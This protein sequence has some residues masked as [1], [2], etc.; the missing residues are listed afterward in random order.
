MRLRSVQASSLSGR[1]AFALQQRSIF[2]LF[3]TTLFFVAVTPRGEAQAT[4]SV[5][6]IV[7]DPQGRVVAGASVQ[8]T[9]SVTGQRRL[10]TSSSAGKFQFPLVAPGSYVVQVNASG[11]KSFIEKNVQVLVNGTSREDAHLA[12]GEAS[13]EVTI[14][15]AAPLVE[16]SNATTGVVVGQQDVVDLPLNGRN[17]AQLGTLIPGVVAAPSGLGG[18]S[19]NA[20]PGGF[21]DA[22]GS[23]NVNG[24]RNQSNNFLLDGAQNND[25]FN[26]GFVMRPPPDAIQEFKIMTHS[27]EAQYGRNSGSVVNV[28]TRSG[29]NRYHATLWDFNREGSLAAKNFF[30]PPGAAKPQYLQNQFGAAGGGRI[31][32]DRWFFFGYYEGYR[33]K[34]ATANTL[35]VPVL[36]AAERSGNFAEL[37]TGTA[38]SS[39]C[40]A[41]GVTGGGRIIDPATGAQFCDNGQPNVIDPA[42]ESA[43]TNNLLKSYIPVPNSAQNQFVEAPPNIDNRDTVGIRSDYKWR[44]HAF[45]GRYL[46]AHQNLYAPLTPSD[47]PVTGSRQ[48]MSLFDGMISDTWILSASSI[49]VARYARQ[50]ING[51]PNK[52]SGIEPSLAGY[53]YQPSNAQALGLPNVT[54]TGYFTQGD[55]Q[56]PFASRKNYV[57]SVDDDFTWVKGRHQLQFGG[58]FRRDAIDLLYINRPNGAFT[59]NGY[60]TSNTLADFF[61]GYPYMFQQGSGNPALDGSSFTYSVYAQDAFHVNRHLTLDVGLRY[62]IN[63]PYAEAHNHLAALHPGQ[64]STVEPSAP[65][66]LVYPGDADTPRATYYAD[67]NNFAPRLGLVYDP[68]GNASTTLRVAW[69]IFYDTVPGQGD[70]FQNGTL[71]PPFQP[72]QEIDFYTRPSSAASSTYFSNP[73]NG[74]SA[75]PVGFPPGLTFIGWSLPHSFQTAQVYQYNAGIQHRV[76]STSGFEIAYVGSRG[77]HLPIF[78]EANPTMV[79]PASS[80]GSAY[81]AGARAVFPALGLTRPTFS[82]A[83]SWYDSLQASYQLRP[84]HHAHATAAYTWSHSIDDVSGL[85]IGSDSRPILPVTIGDQASIDAAMAR[86]RGNSLFDARNRLVLSFGYE[87]PKLMGSNLAKRLFVGGWQ[88]NG[89]FQAQSGSPFTAV[90]ST[91]T[92]QSLTF[93]PNQTCNPNSG[94]HHVGSASPFF[95][96]SCFALPTT[97][98]GR[99]DNSQSGNEARNVILGPRWNN[100]DASLF[101]IFS[102]SETQSVEFRFEVFDLF[103]EAHFAQPSST[104]GSS[105]FGTITSTVGSDQ[106]ILQMALKY[107]F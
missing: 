1:S 66:G 33:V 45:L 98:G 15:S 78:I 9:S 30:T 61:L 50:W 17:F 8:L 81:T 91:T 90:N 79:L 102:L 7:T 34:D 67:I 41:A 58:E 85:N 84:W 51:I 100:T 49:N 82:A 95:N 10:A 47:F 103:N 75:G 105:T 60:F 86:E 55:L 4:G 54:L 96:V 68:T 87:L 28:V 83:G 25:S 3:M 63:L 62:E 56:Q 104:F 72:L 74:V 77:N 36:S 70:F 32:E 38:A 89:I 73:Y 43:I 52:T 11:F 99:I 40:A 57:D 31:L 5:A 14:T 97:T 18:A 21:G 46:Y 35:S 27:Y 92:A 59:Y 39:G 12:L 93:R 71:A 16:T 24:Q 44:G 101:K 69:G 65:V 76:T 80:G 13:E 29:T 22:T 88:I 6:G 106:R 64:Q 26:S 94:T 20:S 48:I 42:R 37:L 23:F 2:F 19:G 53:A 107:G